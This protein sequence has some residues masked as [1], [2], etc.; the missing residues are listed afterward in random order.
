MHI[1]LSPR[2]FWHEQVLEEAR[3]ISRRY[4][5]SFHPQYG[6]Y[7]VDLLARFL[8]VVFLSCLLLYDAIEL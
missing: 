4:T 2:K 1:L 7:D 6:D 3:E 8:Q 5:K